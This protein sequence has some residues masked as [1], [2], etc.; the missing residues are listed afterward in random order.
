[1]GLAEELLNALAKIDDLKVAA[2]T[3]LIFISRKEPVDGGIGRALKC[4]V[5]T[6]RERSQGGQSSPE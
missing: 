5:D 2:R 1:M 4:E 6:R 3:C